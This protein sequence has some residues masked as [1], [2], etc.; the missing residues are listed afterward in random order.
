[1][2][3]VNVKNRLLWITFMVHIITIM[4]TNA[5]YYYKPHH[6]YTLYIF[7]CEI[8]TLNVKT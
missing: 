6:I 7:G 4:A 2:S 3:V 5:K 1:M 8:I